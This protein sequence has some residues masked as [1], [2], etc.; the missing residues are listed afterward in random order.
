MPSDAGGYGFPARLWRSLDHHAARG[1]SLRRR[2][3]S[4]LRGR[5][6]RSV[7]GGVL[8]IGLPIVIITGLLSYLA[9]GRQFGQSL[10]AD[11]GWL[12]LPTFDWPSHPAWLYR[13]TQGVHVGLG[14]VL[15]PVL[16]A[17][18]WSVIPR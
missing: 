3:R 4:P 13:L 16:I 5:W 6:L 8:L 17:K 1:V 9:Y 7:F 2:W 15:V 10:P 14:M 18:L 11:V 12:T